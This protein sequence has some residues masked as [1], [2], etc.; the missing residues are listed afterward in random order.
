MWHSAERGVLVCLCVCVCVGGMQARGVTSLR[1]V[2]VWHR[3]ER[4]VLMCVGVW[5][6]GWV[7]RWYEGGGGG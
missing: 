4:G 5:V 2:F 3:A 7:C 6:D 1:C